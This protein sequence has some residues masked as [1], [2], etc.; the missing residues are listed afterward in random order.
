LTPRRG[1]DGARPRF[2]ASFQP[3]PTAAVRPEQE[4]RPR[5]KV[6]GGIVAIYFEARLSV[7]ISLASK[8][9]FSTTYGK[10]A[11]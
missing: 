7:V 9:Y 4:K 5:S 6:Q 10:N 3:R 8:K 1:A 2:S 11:Y